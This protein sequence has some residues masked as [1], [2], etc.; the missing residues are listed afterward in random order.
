LANVRSFGVVQIRL[1]PPLPTGLNFAGHVDLSLQATEGLKL[2]GLIP[3][4]LNTS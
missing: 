1:L 2:K 3:R 4:A